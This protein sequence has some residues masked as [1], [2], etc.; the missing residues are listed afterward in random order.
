M[1]QINEIQ[2]LILFGFDHCI[3]ALKDKKLSRVVN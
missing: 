2:V 1:N 3:L